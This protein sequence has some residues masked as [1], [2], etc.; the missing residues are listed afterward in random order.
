MA[1]NLNKCLVAAL[2]EIHRLKKDDKNDHGKYKYVSVDDVKDHIRPILAKHN[3][4]VTVSERA[5]E[6]VMVS[7]RNGD[8]TSAK[9]TFDIT[10]HHI[11]GGS[12]PPDSITILLP[13]TGAQTAGAARSY[14]VKEWAKGTLLV[15][16]GEKDHIEGGVDADAYKQQDYTKPRDDKTA[17]QARQ[18]GDDEAFKKIQ[19]GL[20]KIEKEGSM[21]DL[22]LFWKNN[23][24]SLRSMKRS[25][26]ADLTKMKDELKAKFE[27]AA[28]KPL[29]HPSTEDQFTD[30]HDP[31]TGEVLD[32]NDYTAEQ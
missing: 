21:E 14:A 12:L 17:H 7:S 4:I 19:S 18:D 30:N 13:Y 22:A 11:D 23:Q 28:R 9:I 10:I 26:V 15:S 29:D 2:G 1:T 5:F 24:P 32:P 20:H 16:T 3:L 31:D 27:E 6:I 8:T 25:W